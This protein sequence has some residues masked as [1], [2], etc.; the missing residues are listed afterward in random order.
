M[1]EMAIGNLA[2]T[3]IEVRSLVGCFN[4]QITVN[5]WIFSLSCMWV[6]FV[7]ICGKKQLR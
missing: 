5:S 2:C 7:I 3:C 6:A 4:A 1:M